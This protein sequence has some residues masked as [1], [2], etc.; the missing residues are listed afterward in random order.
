MFYIQLF[1]SG[2]FKVTPKLLVIDV[3]FKKTVLLIF[4]LLISNFN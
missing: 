3:T 2:N 4:I 1:I